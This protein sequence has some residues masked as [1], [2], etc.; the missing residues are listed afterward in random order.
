[1]LLSGVV[2]IINHGRVVVSSYFAAI[3]KR[4]EPG[5]PLLCGIQV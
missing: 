2:Q 1:M 4:L 3:L 5:N